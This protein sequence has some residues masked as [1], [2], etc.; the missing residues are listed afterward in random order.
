N[1]GSIRLSGPDDAGPGHNPQLACGDILVRASKLAGADGT[2]EI[3][4]WPPTGDR[5]VVATGTWT[6]PAGDGDVVAVVDGSTL[7]AA[8]EAAG[9]PAHEQQGRHYRITLSQE[10]GAKHKTFWVDCPAPDAAA[11]EATSPGSA[12]AEETEVAGV[13]TVPAPAAL[14]APAAPVEG[15][16][17]LAAAGPVASGAP[18][19]G[20][21]TIVLGTQVARPQALPLTGGNWAAIVLTGMLL[22]GTGTF[23]VRRAGRGGQDDAAAGS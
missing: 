22:T 5:R 2:Y 7:A 1:R 19:T 17:V 3:R 21:E 4:S 11:A 14:E 6:A 9:V 15:A 23:L 12:G 20:A 16:V 10:G 13:V 8:A 18:I